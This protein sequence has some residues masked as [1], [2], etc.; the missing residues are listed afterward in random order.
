[1]YSESNVGNTY[2]R[3]MLRNYILKESTEEKKIEKRI[4]KNEVIFISIYSILRFDTSITENNID[5]YNVL[6]GFYQ[7]I[8]KHNHF[9]RDS[10][11]LLIQDS[12]CTNVYSIPQAISDLN[13]L[14]NYINVRNP[15]PNYISI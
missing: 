9:Y 8:N 3:N 7:P 11:E 6:H 1:M 2:I 13:E 4:K 15:N 14:D 10:L 12:I 5:K